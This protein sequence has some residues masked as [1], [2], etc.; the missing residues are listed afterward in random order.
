[1]LMSSFLP[2]LWDW[3]SITLDLKI[4]IWMSLEP[5]LILVVGPQSSKR[6]KL[7]Q[8]LVYKTGKLLNFG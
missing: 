5:T 7:Q 1:M 8:N 2:I 6:L 4:L 3:K